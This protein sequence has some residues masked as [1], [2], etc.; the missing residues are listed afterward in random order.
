MVTRKAGFLLWQ[1]PSVSTDGVSSHGARLKG[2]NPLDKSG[3]ILH[4]EHLNT[5]YGSVQVLWDIALE[6]GE[7]E[8]V[9]L[10]GSNGAGKT[11]LLNAISGLLPPWQVSDPAHPERSVVDPA[12]L[13]GEAESKDSGGQVRFAGR[14]LAH[15]PAEEIVARGLVHVPQGRRLFPGLTVRENLLQGAFTRGDRGNVQTD[16][17][18]VLEFFPALQRR[19][20][21]PAG[22][23]S[24]GEQQMVAL[25]RGLMARPRLLMIDEMSLGLAPL[26]VDAMIAALEQINRA[27]GTALLIV[28]QDVQVALEHAHRGYVL[29]TGHVSMTGAA[30]Q[31]L[32]DERVRAA[33]LGV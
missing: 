26:V 5:G 3:P 25:G 28:E 16:L 17:A 11:T 13:S 23:L 10:I 18:E 1:Q 6:I 22:R 9:A 29:E 27:R 12:G 30:A 20:Q 33:Y 21:M 7:G 14:D 24:G 2:T 31:L 4:I 19:L 32:A 8:I 15:V